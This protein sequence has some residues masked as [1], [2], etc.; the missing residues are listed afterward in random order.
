MLSSSTFSGSCALE[1]S[2]RDSGRYQKNT[3][4]VHQTYFPMSG[5]SPSRSITTI[6]TITFTIITSR[7][8]LQI[9]WI[10]R[11]PHF[12]CTQLP[13]Q[14]SQIGQTTWYTS[15][16]L[17]VILVQGPF[18]N[19]L[20]IVPTVSDDPRRE[21]NRGLPNRGSERIWQPPNSKGWLGIFAWELQE[22]VGRM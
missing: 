19:L 1:G 8:Y 16:F 11:R 13:N 9:Y 5:Y 6:M 10:G 2:N 17:V 3:K 22:F 7:S 12:Q 14:T 21:S 18:G 15:Q 20:C 4:L